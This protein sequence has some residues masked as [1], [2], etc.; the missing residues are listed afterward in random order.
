MTSATLQLRQLITSFA[1]WKRVKLCVYSRQCL[2]LPGP[3]AV[4]SRVADEWNFTAG[5]GLAT[6]CL[7]GYGT[8]KIS[9]MTGVTSKL[10]TIEFTERRGR[11]AWFV[12]VWRQARQEVE[13]AR[14]GLR[15]EVEDWCVM[16]PLSALFISA[17]LLTPRAVRRCDW[18][19]HRRRSG[20]HHVLQERQVTGR[21]IR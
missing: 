15:R 19:L 3:V 9:A 17:L 6:V 14:V 5:L 7:H 18:L 12:R 2:C 8:R 10:L 21:C 4:R 13:H 20:Q 16:T 11:F 1:A